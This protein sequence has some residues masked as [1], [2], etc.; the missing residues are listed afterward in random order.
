MAR[1]GAHPC[2][3]AY[4]EDLKLYYKLSQGTADSP[5]LTQPEPQ[6]VNAMSLNP[7]LQPQA[8]SSNP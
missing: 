5:D 8:S 3:E 7:S 1:S 6:P 2:K 4:E